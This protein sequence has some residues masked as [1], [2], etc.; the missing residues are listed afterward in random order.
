MELRPE[1]RPPNRAPKFRLVVLA[2]LLALA[3]Y[4]V[5]SPFRYSCLLKTDVAWTMASRIAFTTL[6]RRGSDGECVLDK[7]A[8]GRRPNSVLRDPWG[9]DYRIS[10]HVGI[11]FV[12]SAGPDGVEG[13]RDDIVAVAHDT[14]AP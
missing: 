14:V 6:V 3:A 12:V 10:C 11:V 7:A 4:L 1:V 5:F 2:A 13:N 9:R 8:L